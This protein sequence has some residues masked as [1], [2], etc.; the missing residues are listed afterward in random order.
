VGD[1]TLAPGVRVLRWNRF[2]PFD[3]PFGGQ[4]HRAGVF[5]GKVRAVNVFKDGTEVRDESPTDFEIHI[6]PSILITRLEPVVGISEDGLI[7]TAEC[8]SP[9]LRVFG[10]L[11]YVLEVEAMGF[12]PKYFIYELSNINGENQIRKF[13]HNATGA[14]DT[15]GDPANHADEIVVFN[16]LSEDEGS[17]IASIRITAVDANDNSYET[18]LPVRLVRPMSFRTDGVRHIAEYLE[19]VIVHGP[20]TG[21]IGTTIKYQES[22]SESRQKGVSVTLTNSF[23]QSHGSVQTDDWSEA[24][25]VTNTESETNSVGQT[26]SEGATASE[27][28]GTN[29]NQSQANSVNL[30]STDGTSWGWNLVEGKNQSEYETDITEAYGE[31]SAGISTEVGA[32]GSVPG[33]AKVSGKVGTS[34]G[35]TV[36]GKQGHW[37]NQTFGSS[38][39]SGTHMDSSSSETKAFGSTTTDSVGTSFSG[40][41]AL[42]ATSSLTAEASTTQGSSESMTYSMGGSDS[43][44]ENYSVGNTE[45][46]QESWQESSSEETLFS[47]SSKVPNGKCA[48]VYR[49]AVRHVRVGNL[50]NYDL[51]G[52]RG[53]VGELYFNEWSW[54]PNIA[55]GDTSCD[56]EIPASTLPT[57][58]CFMACP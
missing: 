20:L 45:S 29:Y 21:S 14:V 24:Y 57:P 22:Q 34:L 56:E 51:C 18:A 7:R 50:Y 38:T 36:G 8:S 12:E 48:V 27:T 55:V 37:T 4:G 42:S 33:F 52:V 35:T 1:H 6:E 47:M 41:Y 5:T 2:G 10:G 53:H 19:P 23:T 15:L 40:S 28:Y 9:A 13:T 17:A 58:A 32:E 46:W 11:P 26:H 16:P 3:V 39:S 43:I 44:T 49:Q 31:V 54:S 25:G 30:S